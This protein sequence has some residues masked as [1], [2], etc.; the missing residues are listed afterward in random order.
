MEMNNNVYTLLSNLIPLISEG[1]MTELEAERLLNAAARL[2]SGV[3]TGRTQNLPIIN[4]NS[5]N[6]ELTH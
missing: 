3:P 4:D 1:K 5:D 2:S 6:N